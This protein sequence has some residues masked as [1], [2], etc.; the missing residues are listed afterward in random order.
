MEAV[1]NAAASE[2]FRECKNA[3]C[4]RPEVIGH[5]PAR[6]ELLLHAIMNNHPHLPTNPL[7]RER[8]V[9]LAKFRRTPAQSEAPTTVE[10]SEVA[11]TCEGMA[12]CAEIDT[13]PD[14]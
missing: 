13:A 12:I 1:E 4:D 11:H 3:A 6:D 5:P 7:R 14:Q 2:T 10:E 9:D 8:M